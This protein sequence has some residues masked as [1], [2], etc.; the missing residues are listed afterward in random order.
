VGI[1][2]RLR[3]KT[4]GF[5]AGDENNFQ[6]LDPLIDSLA[7][8]YKTK[9]FTY[10]GVQD[11]AD[12]KESLKHVDV[13]WFEWGNGPII[14][15]TEDTTK[16][17]II[18]RIHRYEVYSDAPKLIDWSRVNKLVFSS[19]SMIGK[20]E[21]KFPVAFSQTD[22]ELVPIG[23]D[24]NL[25]K[26]SPKKPSKKLIYVGRIHPHKNPSLLLQVMAKLV[27]VD[28]DY[29]LDVI[30]SYA[31]ELYEEF[32]RDQIRKLA[33]AENVNVLGWMSQEKVN[34]HLRKA[35][36]FLITSIIEGL[37]QASLEAMACGVCPVVFDYYGS[38]KAYPE[39]F[40]YRT[41]DE[42]IEKI[43]HPVASRE[44]CAEFVKQRYSLSSNTERIIEIIEGL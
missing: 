5:W 8:K 43:M 6:F 34:E 23:V 14:A 33:L 20:F 37:S 2:S 1:L 16:T 13:G 21:Q 9:K 31:D 17:P 24:E 11:N 10:Q 39:K 35:D 15:A 12:L 38:E 41:V 28:R 4:I 32:F 44:E 27:S 18:N 40:L 30:G 42:A 22:P 36:L 26:F 25:F 7:H 3:P 29:K 19:P